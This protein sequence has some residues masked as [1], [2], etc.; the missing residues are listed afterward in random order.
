MNKKTVILGVTGG[1]AAYKSCEIISK[2][3]KLGFNVQVIMTKSAQ[4]FVKP[5]VFQSLT[6]QPVITDMFEKPSVWEIE[7]ISLAKKADLFL[8]APATANIIG[9]VASGIADD[10]LST[11]IMATKAP[12]IFAPAM[13]TVMYQNKIVQKNISKLLELGYN[14]IS[15][16]KGRLACGDVGIGKLADVDII[17]ENVLKIIN[18]VSKDYEGKNIMVTAGPTIEAIDPVRYITNHSSGKM[19][20]AIAEAAIKRGANVTLISGPTNL[21]PP[22][23]CKFIKVTTTE[24]MYNT[25]LDNFDNCDIVIKAAAPSDYKVKEVFS[26]KIK[27][28]DKKI[29]IELVPNPDILKELGSR[30]NKQILVGFAAESDDELKN[31]KEKLEKK[32]LDMICINNILKENVGFG[33]DTNMIT[34]IKR[35]GEKNKLPLMSKIELADKILDE[36]LDIIKSS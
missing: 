19:G 21:T 5:L 9:K 23:D 29:S 18:P 24:E 17:I 27:K 31:G 11:T 35:S 2:L 22:R 10:M 12:V 16:S 7:H 15:P 1:I 20:Y 26:S 3:I 34:I 4:E 13:N 36:I 8:V 28:K 30:K 33:Y 14:F 32:N 6:N 25:V